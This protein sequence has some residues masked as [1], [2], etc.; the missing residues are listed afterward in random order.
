MRIVTALINDK[1]YVDTETTGLSY[2][3]DI[4]TKA[5]RKIFGVKEPTPAQRRKAKDLLFIDLYG[6]SQKKMT[7]G[8][9]K[10]DRKTT[11]TIARAV[12][13]WTGGI[14]EVT[15]VWRPFYSKLG[16]EYR[17]VTDRYGAQ[18]NNIHDS[19]VKNWLWTFI[20]PQGHLQPD[21]YYITMEV[22]REWADIIVIHARRK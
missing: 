16:V 22:V 3:G 1:M 9:Y 12:R 21:S 15:L 5:A 10:M 8:D 11:V 2:T 18:S 14:A 19:S 17:Q 20:R 6:G 13:N 7:K 4:Y